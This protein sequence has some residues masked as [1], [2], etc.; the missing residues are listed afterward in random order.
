MCNDGAGDHDPWSYGPGRDEYVSQK[1]DF[2][3]DNQMGFDQ[4]VP[5]YP[6]WRMNW[7]CIGLLAVLLLLAIF[8]TMRIIELVTLGSSANFVTTPSPEVVAAPPTVPPLPESSCEAGHWNSAGE[9]R[10]C[11]QEYGRGCPTEEEG[12]APATPSRAIEMQFD[13]SDGAV[14]DWTVPKKV[15]CC[16]YERKGCPKPKGLLPPARPADA[17]DPYP[18]EPEARPA[19]AAPAPTTRRPEATEAPATAAPKTT[20]RK[21][22]TT[23]RAPPSRPTPPQATPYS[24]HFG[25]ASWWDL[26]DGEKQKWCCEHRHLGCPGDPHTPPPP[27]APLPTPPAHEV[28][29][30]EPFSCEGDGDPADW[31]AGWSEGKKK[32]CCEHKQ[33]GCPQPS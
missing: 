31:Q 32:W 23:P 27:P 2:V 11:C 1:Y 21:P 14:D 33:R 17:Q 3:S 28:F 22:S 4:A 20:S 5:Q 13:C 29:T 19:A 9:R 16:M 15:L 12:R 25:F 26:W 10:W 24:C 7:C 18:P 30:S 8:L 6:G